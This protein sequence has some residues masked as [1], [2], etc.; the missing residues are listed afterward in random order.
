MPCAG[1]GLTLPHRNGYLYEDGMIKSADGACRPFSADANGTVEGNGMGAVVL[2]PLEEAIRDRDRIYAVIR[3]TAANN[4]GN[5]KVGYTAPSVEG[6]AEVIRRALHMA[7]VEPGSIAYVEAHGT[8][9]ALGDPVEVEGLKKAFRTDQAGFCGR[10][11][12]SPTSATSTPRPAS[13]PSSR[14]LSRWTGRSSLPASIS[15]KSIRR[16]ICR[17]ARFTS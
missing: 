16:S 3:G 17:A 1:S 13:R 4:D 2:K 12:S 8:G 11:R 14:P 15:A 5:R 9:T 7:D 6:Q 10:A